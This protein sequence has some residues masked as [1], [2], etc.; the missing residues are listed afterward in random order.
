MFPVVDRY[1]L[2]RFNEDETQ[3]AANETG[4]IHETVTTT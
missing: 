2:A 4:I 3:G 1:P